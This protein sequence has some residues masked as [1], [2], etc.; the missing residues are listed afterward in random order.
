MNL[1]NAVDCACGNLCN[2][3]ASMEG[4]ASVASES[5]RLAAEFKCPVI[6]DGTERGNS[7][8]QCGGGESGWMAKSALEEH[9]EHNSDASHGAVRG[10]SATWR[11]T[12]SEEY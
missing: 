8:V 4:C 11:L 2:D 9:S 5:A 1:N 3:D 10:R 6:L 7:V 12:Y